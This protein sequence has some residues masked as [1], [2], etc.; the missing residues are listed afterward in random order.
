MDCP[1]CKTD[2][3]CDRAK[4]SAFDK[5]LHCALNERKMQEIWV[6]QDVPEGRRGLRY[7]KERP[8]P[9][10]TLY[11]V[12]APMGY[13]KGHSFDWIR[14]VHKTLKDSEGDLDKL[15]D[16][17]DKSGGLCLPP[18]GPIS[19][20]SNWPSRKVAVPGHWKG[21]TSR[22]K[23]RLTRCSTCCCR[24]GLMT[25][26][27]K[28]SLVYGSKVDCGVFFSFA[29]V[30]VRLWVSLFRIGFMFNQYAIPCYSKPQKYDN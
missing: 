12:R 25:S 26:A 4:T 21:C 15:V 2:A 14:H 28:H 24:K 23:V 3:E 11:I 7:L 13:L 19:R 9:W 29:D 8:A 18:K 17:C 10:G 5:G 1:K 20:D 6:I 30:A 22:V 27:V 16:N